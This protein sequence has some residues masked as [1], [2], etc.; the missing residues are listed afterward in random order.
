MD[1]LSCLRVLPCI[2]GIS[3]LIGGMGPVGTPARRSRLARAIWR[4]KAYL[5]SFSFSGCLTFAGAVDVR[6]PLCCGRPAMLVAT[7]LIFLSHWFPGG[8]SVPLGRGFALRCIGEM[9]LAYLWHISP[10]SCLCYLSLVP[11][12]VLSEQR[13]VL[14]WQHP[15]VP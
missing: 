2:T 8:L 4:A 7:L 13:L 12:L 14:Y 1:C 5:G 15:V 6:R 11:S 10:L 3:Y 9:S